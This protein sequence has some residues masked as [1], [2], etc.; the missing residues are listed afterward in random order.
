[1][2]IFALPPKGALRRRLSSLLPHRP[3]RDRE[4]IGKP[5]DNHAALG[6]CVLSRGTNDVDPGL[7][8][9]TP[10]RKNGHEPTFGKLLANEPICRHHD[11]AALKRGF[12]DRFRIV[13]RKPARDPHSFV[14]AVAWL[15]LLL[16]HRP[17]WFTST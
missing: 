3:R 17:T 6:G 15:V 12:H 7:A 9:D 11:A 14:L 13:G 16:C 1:M 10:I 4:Y 2:H 5:L 8:V